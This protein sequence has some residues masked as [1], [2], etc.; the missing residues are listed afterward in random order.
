MLWRQVFDN[1]IAFLCFSIAALRS[2]TLEPILHTP[3]IAGMHIV[4]IRHS[5]AKCGPRKL[6]IWPA[7]TK[8]LFL[9]LVS[10]IETSFE[11]VKNDLFGP[12]IMQKR[13]FWPSVNFE[14]CTP[15][16]LQVMIKSV[17]SPYQWLVPSNFV[18]PKVPWT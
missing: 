12:W 5:R 15:V 6:F 2:N 1:L 9:H 8:I 3:S 13:H 16:L 17:F 10:L 7:Q 4:N 18:C 11:W 14:L